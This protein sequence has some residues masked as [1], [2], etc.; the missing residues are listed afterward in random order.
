MTEVWRVVKTR[1]ADQAFDGE[2]ARRAGGRWN[3]PGQSAIYTSA[4]ISLAL[5]EILVHLADRKALTSFSVIPA[6]LPAELIETIDPLPRNW[7]S[8]PAP[9]QL[10][11]IGDGW[12]Q[13]RRSLALRVPS[14][15]VPREYNYLINPAHQSIA[16][17]EIGDPEPFTLDSRL[18]R[19]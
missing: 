10:K 6:R 19:G 12:L 9:V 15:I 11:K 16:E 3:S 7:R 8:W 14:V 2:G 5:L 13:S 4:S 17:L 18:A 1:Y